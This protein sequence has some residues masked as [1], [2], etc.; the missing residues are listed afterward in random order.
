MYGHNV[1]IFTNHSAVRAIL[2]KPASNGKHA[3]WWLKVFASG[4]NNLKVVHRPG[5]EN[6]GADALSRNPVTETFNKMDIETVVSN[7]NSSQQTDITTLLY[8]PPSF[9]ITESDFHLEQRKDPKL[10]ELIDYLEKG[11]LPS[12]R[13]EAKRVAARALNF[14]IVDKILYLLDGRPLSRKQAAVPSHLQQEVLHN[15]HR[16]QMAGHFSGT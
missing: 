14:T 2:D 7:I 4:I 12:G 1:T 5:R 8:I 6:L 9:N 15:Y 10:K 13:Q 11:M 3:R 16:R